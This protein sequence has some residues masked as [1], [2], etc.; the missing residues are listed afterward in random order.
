VRELVE[1]AHLGERE[2]ARQI[3]LAEDSD[4][5]RVETV[6]LAHRGDAPR[7]SAA[8]GSRIVDSVN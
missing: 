1:D 7:E 8:H 2:A 4:A 5:T 3:A 6:E